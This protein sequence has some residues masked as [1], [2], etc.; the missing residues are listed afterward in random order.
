MTQFPFRVQVGK[1]YPFGVTFSEKVANFALVSG[2]AHSVD[3][4]LY[5]SDEPSANP[6]YVIPL[7]PVRNRTGNVW[8]IQ[9]DP[10]PDPCYYLYQIDKER[11]L[12]DPYSH[13]I[14]NGKKWGDSHSHPYSPKGVLIASSQFDWGDDCP[15]EIPLQE[16]I[17]YEMH[18][19]GFTHDSSSQTKYPG[20][21]LGI[22]EKIPHLVEL[23]INA[24]ELLPIHEFNECE[25]DRKNPVTQEQ[26]YNYWG[27]STVNFFSPMQR[28][29]TGK[30]KNSAILEFKSMVKELH[31]NGIEV[32]LDVVFNH[33]AEGTAKGPFISFRGIDESLYYLHDVNGKL[34]D[35]TGC[36]NT[37]NVNHPIVR[38]LI[39]NSLRYWVCEMH[40]DGFR[41]DLASIFSRDKFGH[42]ISNS[43]IIEAISKDP[44]L[45]R[46]K[47]I[48]EPWDAAGL[49]QVGSF[50]KQ[51]SGRWSEWNGRYRDSIRRFIKGTGRKEDFITNL[52]GSH[53]LY[54]SQ[55]P[56]CSINFITA[57]DG[58]TLA[59]LVSY[60]NKHNE[61]NGENN[62]DGFNFND[63]W[64]CGV[65]GITTNPQIIALRERQMRNFH[66]ALMVSRGVPMVLMGDE[67]GHSRRGNNNPW[68]QD[69]AFNWFLWN[70]LTE[71]ENFYRFYRKLIHFRKNHPLLHRG[72]FLT[73][74]EVSWHG[75]TPFHPNWGT[76]EQFIAYTLIDNDG[77][78]DLYIAF[79]A[80]GSQ[81]NVEFP[82]TDP[83]HPWVWIV[84]TANDPPEDF[85]DPENR[86]PVETASYQMLPHSALM[87]MRS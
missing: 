80:S 30:D 31:R 78:K 40:V 38:E 85:Y 46:T 21:Y 26:L 54:Y 20:T 19:R 25:Y 22:I 84:N 72:T 62:Q 56:L 47:L 70:E 65:E 82:P 39:I 61:E 16:L 5:L 66:L 32:I 41:F 34:L 14:S 12:L 50:F 49:Y 59:D 81:V 87:L 83:Q 3:L 27:Y 57:H 76:S 6:S 52:C 10:I 18:V 23:G 53:D 29:S 7:D 77:R 64:N 36:G 11:R 43:P 24:I 55:N 71:K 44:I 75:Q 74:Q 2:T 33:T 69:N 1:P 17:I 42:P 4:C 60:N 51:G 15:L 63:S 28:Y 86:K 8:H 58:F 35:L 48:A 67:Y 73:D 68:C 37:L 79:N 13:I 45:F 9:L